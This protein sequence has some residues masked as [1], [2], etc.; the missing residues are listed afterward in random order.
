MKSFVALTYLA[1]FAGASLLSVSQVSAEKAFD[2]PFDRFDPS[3][4][5]FDPP[6]D[7]FGPPFDRFDPRWGFDRRMIEDA[8]NERHRLCD[9]FHRR[10]RWEPPRR[11]RGLSP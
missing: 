10:D 11:C 1:L 9:H 5:R 6:F 3:F 2:P 4:D 7:R 8:E